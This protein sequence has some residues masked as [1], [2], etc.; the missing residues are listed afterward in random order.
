MKK[1]LAF[2]L[3]LLF[4]VSSA[5]AWSLSKRA[6][7]CTDSCLSEISCCNSSPQ[8]TPA[9]PAAPSANSFKEI[10]WALTSFFAEVTEPT[11]L[12]ENPDAQYITPE[13]PPLYLLENS[14]LI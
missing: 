9:T 6:A 7:C 12:G 8:R 13:S 5:G 14:F 3:V 4:Q 11:I 10:G 1:V 2:L